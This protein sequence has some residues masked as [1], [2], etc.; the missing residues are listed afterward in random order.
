[1]RR[2]QIYLDE[3]L[4]EALAL[5]ARR[6]HTSKAALIRKYVAAQ[7]EPTTIGAD[8]LDKLV[9]E[10]NDEPGSID[11]V[12]YGAVAASASGSK[13]RRTNSRRR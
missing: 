9:G 3:E 6:Q 7:I 11:D 2:L 8:P 10:Y 13:G 1:M 4:D 5:R 12:V